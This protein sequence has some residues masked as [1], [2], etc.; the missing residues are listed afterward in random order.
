MR[1]ST[2]RGSGLLALV[3]RIRALN[4]GSLHL[5]FTTGSSSIGLLEDAYF[6]RRSMPIY[7]SGTSRSIATIDASSS[8]F[9]S[10]M[11]F[12]VDVPPSE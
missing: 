3:V 10:A 8:F 1:S 6:F 5:A 9:S 11:F 2:D 4:S 12:V 7:K